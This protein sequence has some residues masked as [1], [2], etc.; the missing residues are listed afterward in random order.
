MKR[1]LASNWS[2]EFQEAVAAYGLTEDIYKCMQCGKCAGIC[3]C[4]AL[5]PSYN[6]RRIIREVLMGND[7]RILHS[8][9]IWRCF[10]CANCASTCP[11]EIMYPM[12]MMV[13]RFVAL[14]HGAGQKH[15]VPL[16]RFTRRLHERAVNF[17]PTNP[18]RLKVIEDCRTKIGLDPMRIVNPGSVKEYQRLFEV[19]GTNE[20]MK[21]IEEKARVPL[22]FAFAPN[23]ILADDMPDS[24]K[25]TGRGA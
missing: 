21:R 15:I 6:P 22:D 12:L 5:Y 1:E 13:L 8:E 24:N 7:D 3:P 14:D 10:W 17:E 18:K 23:V 9:E 16:F 4:A 11:N 19:A 25:N 2:H 20:W